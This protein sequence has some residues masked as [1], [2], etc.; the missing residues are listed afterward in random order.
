MF[1]II[2]RNS[3]FFLLFF[4]LKDLMGINGE[5]FKTSNSKIWDSR[6]F[7]IYTGAMKWLAPMELSAMVRG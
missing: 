4:L 7:Y 2:L 1:L 5:S 6:T 3:K